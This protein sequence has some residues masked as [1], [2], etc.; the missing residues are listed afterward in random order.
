[1]REKD[2]TIKNRDGDYVTYYSIRRAV[3]KTTGG[4]NAVFT[5]GEESTLELTPDFTDGDEEITAPDDKVYTSAVIKKPEAL[6]PENIAEGVSVAG[7]IGTFKGA[8]NMP[9]LRAPSI[10]RSNDTITI[11]NP[12]TNGTFVESY[13]ILNGED[14][15]AEQ[16]GN[17]FSLVGLGYHGLCALAV[18]AS[19]A[20]FKDS[21]SSNV[22]SVYIH[23][24]AYELTGLTSSNTA[25]LISDGLGFSTRLSP[26][27]GVYLP[28][29]ITVT[30]GGG[31]CDSSWN[32]YTGDITISKVQGDLRICAAALDKK[33]LRR[34]T[35]TLE[36]NTL[37]V[38]PPRYAKITKV[39][40][41]GEEVAVYEDKFTWSV[42]AVENATYGFSLNSS[43]Y[44]VS[45][46]KGVQSS[47]AMCKVAFSTDSEREVTLSCIN[48]NETNY[49][50]GIISQINKTLSLSNSD[51]GS[52]GSTNVLKNFKGSCTTAVI[53]IKLVVPAGESYITIKYRKDGSVN[54]GNDAFMFTL[55][56]T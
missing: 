40:I 12:S 15:L 25:S 7:V 17:T 45:G 55:E 10:S 24:I 21:A 50:Y 56:E 22:I 29:D 5:S 46:N 44:Y 32:S 13:N 51:D 2:I 35:V 31:E 1:M 47:Y 23:S 42:E 18:T 39:Y 26:G 19:A 43:G 41:D 37:Y 53:T 30:M 27:D 34:P 4:D 16:K 36:G 6:I 8:G 9:Q 49:D 14:K 33:K 28:E 20:G 38:T 3:F 52:T 11:S 54:N 48:Y